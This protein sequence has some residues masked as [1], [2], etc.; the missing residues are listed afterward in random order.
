MYI[1]NYLN[2]FTLSDLISDLRNVISFLI[3]MLTDIASFFTESML[4][5]LILG[6]ALFGVV[7]N[8]IMAVVN[9]VHK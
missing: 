3:S 1:H 2:E 4:G 7:F 9:K 5:Q 6:I 8:V